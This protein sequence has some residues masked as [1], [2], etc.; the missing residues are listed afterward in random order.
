M[1]HSLPLLELFENGLLRCTGITRYVYIQPDTD[2]GQCGTCS[3][4]PV[5]R[6]SNSAFRAAGLRPGPSR[7][8]V[9]FLVASAL[10]IVPPLASWTGLLDPLV[11]LHAP[12]RA[13]LLVPVRASVDRLHSRLTEGRQN[14]A[15]RQRW[16]DDAGGSEQTADRKCRSQE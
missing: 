11:V 9:G 8:M 15:D 5:R 16:L 2:L 10:L 4:G 1:T 13:A 3:R 7:T 6:F 12:N 14:A